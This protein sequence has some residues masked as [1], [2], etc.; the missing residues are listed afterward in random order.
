MTL[1]IPASMLSL[2][3]C[4]I[5]MLVN[6]RTGIE[7]PFGAGNIEATSIVFNSD[8][9]VTLEG[10]YYKIEVPVIE[11]NCVLAPDQH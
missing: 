4:S 3:D 8:D 9:T 7:I 5:G 2:E 11:N 6:G 10:D 1:R